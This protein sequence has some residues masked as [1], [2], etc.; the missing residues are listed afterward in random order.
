MAYPNVRILIDEK[1]FLKNPESSKLGKRILEG[2]IEMIAQIGF[3]Q[4]TFKKLAERI[5]ST[6]ASVYRYFENKHKLLIYLM[7]W[8]WDWID[9]Q[10][11]F[12]TS[13]IESPEKRLRNCIELLSRPIQL[14][15][16]FEHINEKALYNIVISE[17]SKVYL[18]KEVDTDNK[19]GLFAS[20]KRFVDRVAQIILEINPDYRFS[21]AL[22][23]TVVESVHDQNFFAHHLPSLT[24][25]KKNETE[26]IEEF[27]KELVF[28][29]IS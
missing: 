14:D 15:Q 11:I 21:H 27:V 24:E 8:Y 29:A 9:Y 12:V 7:T 2:A 17:S 25:V 22:I 20:Y 6:E 18:N 13:N 5:E 23:S 10:I 26:R 3:E 19:E 16:T 1:V 4:F 28:K